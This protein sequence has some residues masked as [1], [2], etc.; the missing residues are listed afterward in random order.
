MIDRE[1]Y[2]RTIF[3]SYVKLQDRNTCA[4]PRVCTYCSHQP[5]IAGWYVLMAWDILTIQNCGYHQFII[6]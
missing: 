1:T 4:I 3:H 5:M 6:D 2:K